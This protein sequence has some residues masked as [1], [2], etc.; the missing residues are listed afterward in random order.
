MKKVLLINTNTETKPYPV[1]P[2]GLCVIAESI[3]EKYEVKIF[4]GVFSGNVGLKDLL[5]DFRPDYVGFSLR[6]IDDMTCDNL[7]YYVDNVYRDFIEP[8]KNLTDVPLIIGGSGFSMYPHEILKLYG[9]HYGIV[10]EGE[11]VLSLLLQSLD[12]KENRILLPGLITPDDINFTLNIKVAGNFI[13][14]PALLHKWLD[15]EPYRLRGAY[16]IQT[17]RGCGFRCIYC[18]YPGIEGCNYRLREA[19]HIVD[20]MEAAYRRLGNITFEFVD[21]IF[22]DPAGHAEGICSEIISRKLR[23]NMR[24]MGINPMNS[25]AKLFEL[26]MQAGFRQIDCTP[27]SA[28]TQIL[29]NLDKNF[30]LEHLQQTAI[31]LRE[32]DLPAMWFFMFGGP[33]ENK[34]TIDETFDFIDRYI[35]PEDMVHLTSG[36]RI[37]PGTQLSSIA[38]AQ[39]IIEAGDDLLIPK[40]YFSP[41]LPHEELV[42]VLTQKCKSRK[43]CMMSS[44]TTPPPEMLAEAIEIRKQQNLNEPMFRT[45]LRI[46]NSRKQGN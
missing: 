15:F 3:S 33:G 34:A 13:Q 16:S 22:N 42:S 35:H 41:G 39:G 19:V 38:L 29:K 8:V 11:D 6:N 44:E 14:P 27:D 28:S 37:Y 12:N 26:M 20:E 46:K 18:T 30:S 32:A 9:L 40:F 21:S 23:L 31:L 36:L 45:L 24:T 2:L 7:T 1:P 17:K 4:D 43:N 5:L 25:S 10:G